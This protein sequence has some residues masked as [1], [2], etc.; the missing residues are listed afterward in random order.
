MT[1]RSARHEVV[2]RGSA[3][4]GILDER[5]HGAVIRMITAELVLELVR[6]LPGFSMLWPLISHKALLSGGGSAARATDRRMSARLI[7][8]GWSLAGS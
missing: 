4:L 7:A 1:T 8:A 5:I 6:L 3:A 2:E